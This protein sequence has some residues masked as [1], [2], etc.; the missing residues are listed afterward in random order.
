MT[1]GEAGVHAVALVAGVGV[2]RRV[3]ARERRRHDGCQIC[4]DH[5]P[6]PT[7]WNL[8]FHPVSGSQ[9]SNLMSESFVGLIVPATRQKA[10]SRSY[11]GARPGLR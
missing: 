1:E 3:A 5:T 2:R 10:G 11:A 9:T 8:P 4:P 6:L 7:A